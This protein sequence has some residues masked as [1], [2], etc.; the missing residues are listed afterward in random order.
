MAWKNTNSRYGTLAKAFH[1]LTFLLVVTLLIVGYLMDDFDGAIRP[2]MYT[3]HKLFGL[4]LLLL[5]ALRIIW[6][7]ANPK[8]KLPKGTSYLEK[9]AEHFVHGAMYLLLFIM[10]L[11]GW[12]MST[13]AGKAPT[14]YGLFSIPMP[15]VPLN[16]AWAKIAFSIHEISAILIIIFVCIHVAA[17]LY[18]HYVREDN[19]L[20]RMLPG[21]DHRNFDA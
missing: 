2:F 6:A 3:T 15:F 16:K 18:H 21:D 5:M 13:A 4:L 19:I 9:F 17:A 12:F 20:I 10:P 7:L 8:P 1:W 11:A 14:F